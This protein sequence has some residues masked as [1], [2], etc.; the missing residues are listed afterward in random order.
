MHCVQMDAPPGEKKPAEQVRH[1]D[2]PATVKNP[3][4]H[5]SCV[6]L[7]AH[8]EPAAQ[9][10]QTALE[11]YVAVEW[12]PGAQKVHDEDAAMA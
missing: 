9:A 5:G 6:P 2:I 3:A 7:P 12:R 10:P 11:V 8:M 4:V 1:E